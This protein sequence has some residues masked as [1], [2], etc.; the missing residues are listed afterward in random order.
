ARTRSS[1]RR[2]TPVAEGT[3]PDGRRTPNTKIG[4]PNSNALEMNPA[5]RKSV[6]ATSLNASSTDQPSLGSRGDDTRTAAAIVPGNDGSSPM[7]SSQVILVSVTS[8]LVTVAA[9]LLVSALR[10]RGRRPEDDP[11]R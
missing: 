11:E 6:N 9:M 10:R 2:P 7:T 1:T 3:A 8:S 5:S 4:R